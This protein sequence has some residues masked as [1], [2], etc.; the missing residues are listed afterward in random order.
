MHLDNGGVASM[1]G[2]NLSRS[3]NV[4]GDYVKLINML[5]PSYNYTV[6]VA[7]ATSAG[8]GVFSVPLTVTMPEDGKSVVDI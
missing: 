5:H 3:Y 4:T 7:A 2:T 8:I 1:M 6:S